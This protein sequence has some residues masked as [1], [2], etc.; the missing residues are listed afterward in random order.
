[1]TD[2]KVAILGSFRQHYPEVLKAISE[3][4]RVGIQILSPTVSRIINPDQNFVRFETD[5]LNSTDSEIQLKTLSKIFAADLVFV[6]APNGYIG[7]TTCYE[8]G[9]VHERQIP[10]FFSN[11][12]LDLPIVVR[13][14][15]ITSARQLAEMIVNL[16][17]VPSIPNDGVPEK[18]RELE[19]SLA[20]ITPRS[21]NI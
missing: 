15:A 12:P 8:I 9:R 21:P 7:R 11:F 2:V 18:V 1:M 16:G 20:L 4:E 17:D 13:K 14:G 5:S 10:V 3:F 19:I 6:V